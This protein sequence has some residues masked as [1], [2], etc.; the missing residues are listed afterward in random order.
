MPY[1]VKIYNGDGEYV[2]TI[3][4][5]FD[6]SG[7]HNKRVYSAHPCAGCND[8]TTNKK[9]CSVCAYKRSNR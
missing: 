6:Y 1:P 3:M 7:K 2:K 8:K 5:E 9:Y 4:P